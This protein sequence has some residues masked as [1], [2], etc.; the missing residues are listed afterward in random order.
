MTAQ[1]TRDCKHPGCRTAIHPCREN[2]GYC[3]RHLWDANEQQRRKRMARDKRRGHQPSKYMRPAWR[4]IRK[5]Q[6]EREPQCRKCGAQASHVD[7]VVAKAQ[8]G[9][10]EGRNLQSLCRA[11]HS[12][13]TTSRDGGFGNARC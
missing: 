1:L 10:D 13:K 12:R 9:S 8:G 3:S 11:C 7:H 2:R 4:K 6:L 5:Q